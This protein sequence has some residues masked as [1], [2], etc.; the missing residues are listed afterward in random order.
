M[1]QDIDT[2]PSTRAGITVGTSPWGPDDQLGALNYLKE[3]VRVDMLARADA[4]TLYDLSVDY[5]VGMPSFQGAGDP[6]Y[7]IFLSHTPQGT[8]VDNLN[9]AGDAVN[10]HVCYSGD[11]VFM[12]THT[13]TH[14]DALNHFGVDGE[15]YNNF[16]VEENLG[17]RSWTKGGAEQIPPIITRGV[18]IDVAKLHGVECLPDSYPIT[19][20]D[21]QGALGAAGLQLNEGDVP[22]VRTGRMRYWPDGAKTLGNPPGLSLDAARWLTDQKIAAVGS[23]QECVEVGPSE[24]EDN[25]L[26]GHCHFL[27]ETGV[28]MIELLNLEELSADGVD[29]FCLMAAPIR[30]RGASGAPMRPIAMAL[31]D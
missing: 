20:D 26:P 2:K 17:S 19:V 5:F 8:L 3:D 31:R 1:S 21:L 10:R 9:G 27:A 6:G 4:S 24:H 18:L 13:G 28:P 30:L 12:Y 22:F 7:Q 11:V 16:G 29:E 23:D 15:I 14:I 25:W